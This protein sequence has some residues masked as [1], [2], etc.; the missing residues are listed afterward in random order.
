M[1]VLFGRR[2]L[3]GAAACSLVIGFLSGC[4]DGP[5]S[6]RPSAQSSSPVMPVTAV[7]PP[8]ATPTTVSTP[9]PAG[10]S[11]NT[12]AQLTAPQRPRAQAIPTVRPPEAVTAAPVARSPTRRQS[13]KAAVTC[14]SIKQGQASYETA[15][16]VCKNTT[17]L[18]HT[19]YLDINAPGYTNLPSAVALRG[20][21]LLAPGETKRVAR[22]K[23]AS[24]PAMLAINTRAVPFKA[25]QMPG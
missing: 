18:I 16:I 9:A 17:E 15:D 25:V 3:Q 6:A 12:T 4:A 23:V 8:A 2:L 14:A 11:P 22:L 21:Y 13:D 19:V 24:R 7:V 1:G 20:G 10:A 5:E